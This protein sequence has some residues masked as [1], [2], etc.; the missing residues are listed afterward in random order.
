MVPPL[1]NSVNSDTLA[2]TAKRLKC[3]T[4]RPDDSTYNYTSGPVLTILSVV[5][6][7]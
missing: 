3:R 2:I 5:D 1:L 6:G 7:R 4:S